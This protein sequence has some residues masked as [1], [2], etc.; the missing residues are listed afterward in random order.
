[1]GWLNRG[2]QKPRSSAVMT[3]A[4]QRIDLQDRNVINAIAATKMNWQHQAWNYRDLV[5]EMGSALRFRA[6]ALSKVGYIIAQV[7]DLEDEPIRIDAE[8]CTLD[9]AVAQA[10]QDALNRLPW[11]NGM[12]FGGTVDTCFN[13]TGEAWLHGRTDPKT[14]EETWVVRSTDEIQ[15][16]AGASALGVVEVPGRPAKPIDVKND[17]LLRLWVPH[18]RFKALADAPMRWMLDVCEDIVLI[19]RE[20]RAASR[21]RIAANGILFL[22]DSMHLARREPGSNDSDAET[23]E[24]SAEFEAAVLAPIANEGDAGSVVPIVIRGDAEDIAAVQH[25]TFDRETSPTLIDK[26]NNALKRMGETLDVPPTVVTGIQDTNHWNAYVIDAQTWSNHLEPGQRMIVDSATEAYLRP[27]LALPVTEGGYGLSPDQ[28]RTVQIW[29]DAGKVTE[30]PNR[31]ADAQ[32]AYTAGVIGPKTLRRN[33]GFEESD[34]PTEDEQRMMLAFKTAPD[35]AT[36]GALI[37]QAFGVPQV[38]QAAPGGVAPSGLPAGPSVTRQ[39]IAP[40]IGHQPPARALPANQASVPAG[41]PS[42]G[43]PS[44]PAGVAIRGA[45]HAQRVLDS[46]PGLKIIDGTRLVEIDRELR[47][48]LLVACDSAVTEAIEKAGKRVASAAQHKVDKGVLAAHRG[49]ELALFLGPE[50]VAELGVTEDM[51]LAAAFAYLATKFISWT[52]SAVKQAVKFAAATYGLELTAVAQLSR[53]LLARIPASW[54]HLEHSLRQRA[55]NK[56]FGKGGTEQHLGEQVDSIVMPGDIR[57]AL[58]KIGGEPASGVTEG[59]RSD[60]PLGGI[61]T[62]GDLTAAID[63]VNDRIGWL[64][65]YG[66]TDRGRHFEP[67]LALDGVK[68]T[69]WTEAT[70]KTDGRDVWV[71]PYFHPG[72]HDGCLCDFIPVWAIPD[73]IDRLERDL[74]A[75]EAPSMQSDRVLADLDRA[76]GRTGTT[77]QQNVTQRQRVIDAQQRWLTNARRA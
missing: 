47:A 19:G 32:A 20:L 23:D 16:V 58:A 40:P 68:F 70:L 74:A 48:K 31:S 45:A 7:N 12:S 57:S 1:M 75:P 22:P 24:F 54:N 52:T 36:A 17:T 11:R 44:A 51:L 65:K 43:Q 56:L 39:S 2:M 55:M 46:D 77:A 26:L 49:A 6:N 30:N 14:R 60:A 29:Y 63:K 4:G 37:S 53:T 76:A 21:S 72:D 33:M 9:P 42:A 15:P 34:A 67:H 62:G 69:S 64:W 73:H 27:I 28:A 61:A 8:N 41:N 38:V 13:V 59:G 66:I 71:G 3:A 10:A 5:G 18:P 25:I 35:P 50:A